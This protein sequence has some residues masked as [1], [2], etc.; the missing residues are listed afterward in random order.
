MVAEAIICCKEK[1]FKL[2]TSVNLAFPFKEDDVMINQFLAGQFEAALLQLKYEISS[3]T[4]KEN[5]WAL[6]NDIKNSAGTIALHLIGNLNH[7][8]GATL[9]NTGYIRN[10]EVE[11]T[12]R[13]VPSSKLMKE[14]DE[15]TY[16]VK[17]IV[18]N[19]TDAD[20]SNEYPLKDGKPATKTVE[21]LVHLLAHL[22]Y[23]LG[24]INYHRRLIEQPVS[25]P[26]DVDWLDKRI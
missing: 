10:R 13:N 26:D 5:L 4:H 17:I 6:H 16:R 24:Q 12:E 25:L 1:T 19:L 21:R 23:H 9:G 2:F 11:F 7:F 18:G 14:I 15:V 3:Y 8:V 22:N 20:L